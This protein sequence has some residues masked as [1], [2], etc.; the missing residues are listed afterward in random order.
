MSKSGGIIFNSDIGFRTSPQNMTV[1]PG[2]YSDFFHQGNDY[3]M[4]TQQ[5]R[6]NTF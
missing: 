4:L 5:G 6:I 2:L 3:N 1:T